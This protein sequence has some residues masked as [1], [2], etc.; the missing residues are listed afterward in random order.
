[1]S[2]LLS[3]ARHGRRV[4]LGAGGFCLFFTLL[5][6]ALCLIIQQTA[7]TAWVE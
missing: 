2:S 5:F 4:L 6:I 1:M 7:D 3:Y